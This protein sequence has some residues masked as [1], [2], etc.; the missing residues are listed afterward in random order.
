[1]ARSTEIVVPGLKNLPMQGGQAAV[2]LKGVDAYD[3]YRIGD[4]ITVK[5]DNDV[6]ANA[7]VQG[8]QVGALV[9][10]MGSYGPQNVYTYGRGYSALS[11]IQTLGDA[12]GENPLDVTKLYTVVTVMV[13]MQP[14]PGM[15]GYPT[16]TV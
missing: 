16:P 3:Q 7:T 5:G 6:T 8:I 13:A 2:F 14:Q 9:D 1:M 12:T 15:P 10:L 4:Q 11:F